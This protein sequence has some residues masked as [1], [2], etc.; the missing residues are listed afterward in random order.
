M[1]P[2]SQVAGSR[3]EE[4]G[5]M[6]PAVRSP[7]VTRR[8]TLAAMAFGALALAEVLTSSALTGSV[9]LNTLC[10]V[11]TAA[12]LAFLRLAPLT[13]AA[14]ALSAATVLT[15]ALT[16]ATDSLAYLVLLALIACGTA[17]WARSTTAA[18][19][20]LALCLVQPLVGLVLL[21]GDPWEDLLFWLP[22]VLSCWLVGGVARVRA[23]AADERASERVA[24]AERE[25]HAAE[26]ERARV[27][28]ELH[29][30]VAHA[31]TLATIQAQ[32]AREALPA[33]AEDSHAALA[34]L[35][36][37]CRAALED[38]RRM[39][40]VL[41]A[42]DSPR[43]P[44][45]GLDDLQAL[46]ERARSSGRTVALRIDP[47]ALTGVAPGAASTVHRIV[48]EGVT[49]ALRHA[50]G[51]A[52]EIDVGRHADELVVE[53]RNGP[54]RGGV[55]AIASTGTGLA[56]MRERVA[57]WDGRMDAG[58][59]EDGG[60]TLVARLRDAVTA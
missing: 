51:A 2:S 48:Q 26:T 50:P 49:N 3:S 1:P 14:T 35:E 42:A 4:D 46:A 55:A 19:A 59:S 16:P 13:A 44:Q 29:D 21:T 56:G 9:R 23:Q 11:M 33:G 8:E 18:A 17:V 38:L 24:Q 22:F 39:L 41:R 40:G 28:R 36:R 30:V 60:W 20:A 52:I 12:P 5:L 37:T 57:L 27:A 25:R 47:A 31:V 53:V 45:P 43:A 58:P 15:G 10:V 6:A 54:G 34:A 7:T 32:V